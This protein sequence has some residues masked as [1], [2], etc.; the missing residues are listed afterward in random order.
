MIKFVLYIITTFFFLENFAYKNRQLALG[1]SYQRLTKTILR[2]AD[3][4]LS[5]PRTSLL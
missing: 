5:L 3:Y 2:P 4:A 1:R